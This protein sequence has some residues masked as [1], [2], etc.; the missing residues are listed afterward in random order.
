MILLCFFFQHFPFCNFSIFIIYLSLYVH[1]VIQRWL[2]DA[3]DVWRIFFSCSVITSPSWP[4]P[5]HM[6]SPF[7]ALHAWKQMSFFLD[8]CTCCNLKASFTSSLLIAPSM[9][10]LFAKIN[11]GAWDNSRSSITLCNSSDALYIRSLSELSTT[12]IIA[13]ILSK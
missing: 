12:N 6:P 9:S 4:I 11:I 2:W 5:S 10:C 7:L 8:S 13:L 3:T 1:S